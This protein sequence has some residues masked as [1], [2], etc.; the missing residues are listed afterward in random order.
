MKKFLVS[1]LIL[2]LMFGAAACGSC[3]GRED[4]ISNG[5]GIVFAGGETS[6]SIVISESS[7]ETVAY[8]AQELSSFVRQATGVSLP[9][10]RDAASPAHYI[11]LGDT[12]QYVSAAISFDAIALRHDGFILREKGGNLYIAGEN[13][14]GILYGVYDFLER[15]AGV[16][17]VAHD[18]T[19][20][21]QAE[22]LS[23]D[24]GTDI[25]EA[26]LFRYRNYYTG[27]I[28]EY[29]AFAARLRMYSEQ[30]P[31]EGTYGYEGDFYQ[32]ETYGNTHNIFDYLRENE[33]PKSDPAYSDF[34]VS[35][36]KQIT[37][38]DDVCY[39]NGV[40]ENGE[41]EYTF[42][43]QKTVANIVLHSLIEFAAADPDAK[44]FMIGIND[45]ADSFCSCELCSART[46][47][48]G[49]FRSANHILFMNLMARELKKVYPE[50]DINIVFF[51]YYWTEQPPVK[52]ENGQYVALDDKLVLEDNL[53]VRYAPINANLAYAV[54][55]SAHNGSSYSTLNRWRALTD[56]F[57]LWDYQEYFDNYAWYMPT[58][59]TLADGIAW[60]AEI[61]VEGLLQLA[62]YNEPED[63]QSKLKSYVASK[64]Y[65][66]ADA[67]V[68][69]LVDEFVTLY[70]GA[71]AAPYVVQFIDIM[72]SHFAYLRSGGNFSINTL[73]GGVHY[74]S[75]ETYP[76]AL[77]QTCIDLLKD[78]QQAVSGNQKLTE[79]QKN[80]YIERLHE[81]SVTPKIMLFENYDSYYE[82]GKGEAAE[83]LFEAFDAAGITC[84]GEHISLAQ[85][86][87]AK[88]YLND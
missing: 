6:Y 62:A 28:S 48:Y 87:A 11:S 24:E 67:N 30:T 61:G 82:T 45:A 31:D 69:E 14:R 81:V 35:N 34:Y 1:F 5:T 27:D 55:D 37:T 38:F 73:F 16:R 4:E 39:S 74:L 79:L 71:D 80:E 9:V 19:Y 10:V 54:G 2:S 18:C 43:E 49:G 57:F 50:R 63:W 86:K 85:Y 42:D 84:V 72:E 66:N 29:P 88:G 36:F 70:Y 65:W 75:Y 22:T 83:A 7:S 41:L 12:Q 78:A 59:G 52:E 58:L 3:G 23:F 60:Y 21:P 47:Q 64:L 20:V 33:Y 40:D 25:S 44:F 46:E 56:N 26:P 8:A 53:Y 13:D 76:A 68:G 77:L 17:F 32:N 51:A 15:F